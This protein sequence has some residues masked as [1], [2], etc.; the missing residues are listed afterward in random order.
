MTYHVGLTTGTGGVEACVFD[1]PGCRTVA[2]DR[3]AVLALVPV[4]IA[5]HLSWLCGHGEVVRDDSPFKLEVTEEVDVTTLLDVADGEFV[6]QD[7]L[8]PV[9]EEEMGSAVRRMGF[10]RQDLLK[11]VGPLPEPVLDWHLPPTAAVRVDDWAPEVRS[12]RGIVEHIANADGYYAANVGDTPWPRMG[13]AERADLLGQRQRA[14]DRLRALTAEE[15]SQLFQRRQPW[16]KEGHEHWTVRKAL[17]RFVEHE[18]FHTREI[19]QRLAWL[20]LGVPQTA[21]PEV[22]A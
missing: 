17:R 10:A 7:D 13:D 22:R 21:A 11:L 2:P 5:E 15:R 12:I 19:E 14:I 1:L 6:F 9:T 20:L 18:R 3:Q 8:R 16:Q 4:A